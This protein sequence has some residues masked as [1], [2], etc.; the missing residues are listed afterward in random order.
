M[1]RGEGDERS[2]RKEEGGE[3]RG[4]TLREDQ[5]HD[6]KNTHWLSAGFRG[7]ESEAPTATAWRGMSS[8]YDLSEKE[9]EK[10]HMK[11]VSY[12]RQKDEGIVL[13]LKGSQNF[14][15]QLR[16]RAVCGMG[17]NCAYGQVILWVNTTL[18]I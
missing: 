6:R 14:G 1:D 11:L 7:H 8:S 2:R 10:G 18:C 9:R 17:H 3:C 16:I 12:K 15:S 4:D 13:I 5:A